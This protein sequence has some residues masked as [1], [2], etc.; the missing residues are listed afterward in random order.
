MTGAEINKKIFQL[1]LEARI[2]TAPAG[3]QIHSRLGAESNPIFWSV[4][5][6]VQQKATPFWSDCKRTLSLT[7]L[8]IHVFTVPH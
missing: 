7:I 1:H 4:Y 2:G 8:H 6:G 5:I 3:V